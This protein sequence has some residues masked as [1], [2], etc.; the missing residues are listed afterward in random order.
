MLPGFS[1]NRPGRLNS[2]KR[3]ACRLPSTAKTLGVSFPF[4]LLGRAD[5]L[6][7]SRSQADD[8]KVGRKATK[9]GRPACR[10][11]PLMSVVQGRAMRLAGDQN[12]A[13]D[14]KRKYA[15]RL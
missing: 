7:K 6:T 12:D 9:K 2:S 15:G 3:S 4:T 11:G 13:D 1:F 10:A 14:P 8:I 5:Q